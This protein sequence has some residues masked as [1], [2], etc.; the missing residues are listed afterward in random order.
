MIGP[1]PLPTPTSS[2]LQPPRFRQKME[3]KRRVSPELLR[4]RSPSSGH[5]FRR[6]TYGFSPTFPALAASWG[7]KLCFM[8]VII[9][10]NFQFS[11]ET[12]S[13]FRQKVSVFSKWARHRGD[14]GNSTEFFS[15]FEKFGAG[16]FNWYQSPRFNFLWTLHLM[17]ILKSWAL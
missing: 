4:R 2:R 12:L 1:S 11:G 17:C 9:L 6:A 7:Y 5:R 16:P 3:K 14:V 15:S 8:Q 13:K 10:E